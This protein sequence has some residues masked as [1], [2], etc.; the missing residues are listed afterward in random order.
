[1]DRIGMRRRAEDTL[2]EFETVVDC[3]QAFA[4]VDF[5]EV[6]ALG[7]RVSGRFPVED[8]GDG[9]WVHEVTNE[10][11]LDPAVPHRWPVSRWPTNEESP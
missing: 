11:W 4:V 9:G 5:G 6:E 8:D 1:M 3:G 2:L 10:V 7:G